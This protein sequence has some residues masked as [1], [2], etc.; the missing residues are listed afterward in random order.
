[1]TSG[2]EVVT[3][4]YTTGPTSCCIHSSH[5]CVLIAEDENPD[6]RLLES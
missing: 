3:L 2:M 6:K 5:A 1:M 4:I